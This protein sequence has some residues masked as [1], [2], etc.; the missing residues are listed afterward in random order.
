M[1]HRRTTNV[2]GPTVFFALTQPVLFQ[3]VL[4]NIKFYRT[5]AP[6]KRIS[7]TTK[8]TRFESRPEILNRIGL[9]QC[10]LK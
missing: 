6:T 7:H 3:T 1:K 9:V 5:A 10:V 4:T 2:D 8:K